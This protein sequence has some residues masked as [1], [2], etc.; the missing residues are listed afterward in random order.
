MKLNEKISLRERKLRIRHSNRNA[1]KEKQEKEKK[2]EKNWKIVNKLENDPN[3]GVQHDGPIKAYEK[4]T[5]K[6]KRKWY[7]VKKK[8]SKKAKFTKKSKK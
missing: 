1:N 8:P 6:R 3:A 7:P 5:K 4:P 2:K